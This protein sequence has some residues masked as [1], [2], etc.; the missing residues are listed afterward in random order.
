MTRR[1]LAVSCLALACSSWA[2][3]ASGDEAADF[4]K[5]ARAAFEARDFAGAAAAFE[6]AYRVKPHPA[7]KY[8]AAL[9]WEKANELARAADAFE[10]ALASDGLDE[11]RAKAARSRLATLKPML[12]YVFVEKPIGATLSVAHVADAPIPTRFHLPPGTHKLVIKRRDG[13]QAEHE[14]A[15]KAGGTT[16][17]A[18]DGADLTAPA[19]G[20]APAPPAAPLPPSR[21][22]PDAAAPR[23]KKSAGCA[24]CTWGW[25][26]LGAGVAAAGAGT[27]FGVRT[28]AAKGDFDDSDKTDADAHDRAVQS[29]TFANVAF[30]VAAVAGGVGIYL[31]LSGG[32]D[33]ESAT[34]SLGVNPSGVSGKWRF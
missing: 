32:E 15:L 28:L 18:L 10:S 34:V 17:V 2:S 26:A 6:E 13:S 8:N 20:P 11:G 29:R 21:V 16:T 24:R 23:P 12:G 30:G 33:K 25:V 4:D 19:K 14:V 7:T 22:A 3:L 9:A 31:L 27:Y 5:K 1:H